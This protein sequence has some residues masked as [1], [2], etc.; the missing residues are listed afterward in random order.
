MYVKKW[1]SLH[2][3]LDC[4]LSYVKC[5][6]EILERKSN[7]LLKREGDNDGKNFP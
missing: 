7:H 1:Q 4:V 5:N 3:F 6:L 2:N